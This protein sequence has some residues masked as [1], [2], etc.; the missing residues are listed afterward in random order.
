MVVRT[1]PVLRSFHTSSSGLTSAIGGAN[2]V[3]L[4][5][6]F[7]LVGMAGFLN[8]LVIVGTIFI[9]G[10]FTFSDVTIV[11]IVVDVI[12]FRRKVQ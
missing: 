10:L 8:W 4:F 5:L 12:Y 2:V 6:P 11:V 3:L 9:L 7:N 1:S